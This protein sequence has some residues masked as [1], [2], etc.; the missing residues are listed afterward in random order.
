MYLLAFL[1]N[2]IFVLYLK[3]LLLNFDIIINFTISTIIFMKKFKIYQKTKI[4]L[5]K[6]PKTQMIKLQKKFQKLLII[7]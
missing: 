6:N 5:I 1:N 4:K 2:H 3:K 7:Y